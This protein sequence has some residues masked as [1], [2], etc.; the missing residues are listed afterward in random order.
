[1]GNLGGLRREDGR[2]PDGGGAVGTCIACM[3]T[4]VFRIGG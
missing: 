2:G 4:C 1:M 3:S